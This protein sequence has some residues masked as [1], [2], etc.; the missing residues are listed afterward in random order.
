MGMTRPRDRQQRRRRDACTAV[1]AEPSAI[2]VG[3]IGAVCN[4]TLNEQGLL[5][6]L[7]AEVPGMAGKPIESVEN[8]CAT[9]GQA[10]LSVVY[11]L[12][13]SGTATS[14]SPS[15]SRRCATPR[16]RWTAS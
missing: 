4:I 11:K 13:S 9:G 6:G 1:K 15:A 10:I 8:A 3:S 7:L 2:D 12:L 5:S 16:A 14:A